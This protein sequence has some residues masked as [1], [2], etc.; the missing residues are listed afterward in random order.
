M[1]HELRKRG[2]SRKIGSIEVTALS[3]GPFPATLDSFID[4]PRAEAERLTGA[5]PGDPLFLPVNAYLLRIGTK[6]ALVDTGCGPTMGPD[7]GQLPDNLRALGV[8]PDQIDYV[9]LTHIHPDHALG[10]IDAAGG[11]VFPN[12]EL[13]L[14][15]REAA[16]WLNREAA[17]GASERIRRNITKGQTACA[18]YRDRL[19]VVGDGEALP[20]VAAMLL[21]GH[22]PGHTGWLIQDGRDGV[23]IWGDVVHLA[24]VQIPR[25]DAALVFDVDPD[26]A[27]STRRRIFDQVAAD[28]LGVAGA[29]LDFPGFGFIVRQGSGY[30]FE[31][32]G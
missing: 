3:D 27:R 12:A 16:F 4:F 18:P 25:P 21:P 32:D 29:H 20:G 13:I 15:E 23:L 31:P 7:L 10:L 5:K 19:R 30:R 14:H 1:D 8:A 9:L 22:T 6:W 24:A 11:A 28:R 17:T 26:M 2:T